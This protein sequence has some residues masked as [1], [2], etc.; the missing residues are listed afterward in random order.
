MHRTPE[1]P[2]TEHLPE[3]ARAVEL[4]RATAL[5]REAEHRARPVG[6]I[7]IGVGVDNPEAQRLY[8]RLGY[9]LLG[10]QVTT[11]YDYVDAHGVRRR[12]TETD[13]WMEKDLTAP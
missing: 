9:R 5:I 7:R 4:I 12:A 10:E 6:R 3:L 11:S 8:L 13:E 1:D 2:I